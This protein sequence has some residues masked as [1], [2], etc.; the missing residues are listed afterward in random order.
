VI[1]EFAIDPGKPVYS[2]II[3]GMKKAIARGE[4]LPGEKIA[5]QRDLA[6]KLKVNANTVQRAYRDMER[7]GLVQTTRGEGTYILSDPGLVEKVRDEMAIQAMVSFFE[8]MVS[9]GFE[10]SEIGKMVQQALKEQPER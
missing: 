6:S 10:R 3:D 4:V 7:M 2:Q 9:L 8:E 1:V 5:S